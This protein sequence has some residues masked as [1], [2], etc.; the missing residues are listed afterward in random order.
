M[1]RRCRHVLSLEIW[2]MAEKQEFFCSE[3]AK[4]HGKGIRN[5]GPQGEK[6]GLV[7]MYNCRSYRVSVSDHDQLVSVGPQR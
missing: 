3:L 6:I 2:R 4:W 1:S 7:V 5:A